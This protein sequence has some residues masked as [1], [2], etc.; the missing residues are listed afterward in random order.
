MTNETVKLSK[1]AQSSTF[2]GN[3]YAVNTYRAGNIGGNS[4]LEI[5]GTTMLYNKVNGTNDMPRTYRDEVEQSRFF[6]RY[7]PLAAVVINRMVDM[8]AAK[9][10]NRRGECSDEEIAYYNGVAATVNPFI[11]MM[12][13]EYL[14]TG[15]VIPEY[16]IGRMMGSRF[17]SLLGRKRYAIP[18][19]FWLRNSD[20]IVLKR[21]PAGVDRAVF[22]RIP[23]DERTF[24]MNKGKRADGTEDKEL[25]ELLLRKF[26]EYVK[27]IQEGK[28]LIEL[29]HTKPILRKATPNA[30][31]PQPYLVPS[32]SA[33]KHKWRIKQMDYSIA[34]RAIEAI[35]H[36]KV[37]SDDFPVV[38]GDTAIEEIR[39]QMS[40]RP[41]IFT[42]QESLY[43]L[44]TNHTVEIGWV[45][46][47][48]DALLSDEK[49]SEPNSDILLGMG[50]SRVLLVGESL[51]S[52]SGGDASTMGPISTLYEMRNAIVF[53]M[54]NMYY[55]LA[56][57]NG[58]RNIPEPFFPTIASSEIT[59][60]VEFALDAVRLGRMSSDTMLQ[61]FGSDFEAEHQQID[62]E[63]KA[64][65]A[66]PVPDAAPVPVGPA[67]DLEQQKVDL[68]SKQHEDDMKM[69][70]KQLDTQKNQPIVAP[71]SQPVAK[72]AELD[73]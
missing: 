8:A 11:G 33:F 41:G 32:L 17:H 48:L 4:P 51:R 7:D 49:Y 58:F 1:S 36:V 64:G 60:L 50:F 62:A 39:Q 59:K 22:L 15:M 66:D 5:P 10:K 54:R 31:Y 73:V 56:D 40:N 14:I 23:E 55:R 37:G 20:Y 46:P 53:W 6:Y 38:D 27:L 29:Q 69:Q 35:R 34:T 12:M 13:L 28:S 2:I 70:K 16:G 21:M 9:L 45:Y 19:P 67:L 3:P 72:T 68:Q 44:Y 57:E 26:P 42:E 30:D 63:G 43:T 24:I 18:D 47:P 65:V 61:M 25:Y 71:T 52:N